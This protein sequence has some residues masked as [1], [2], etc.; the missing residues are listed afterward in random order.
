MQQPSTPA[1]RAQGGVPLRRAGSRGQ[2]APSADDLRRIGST[3][4]RGS[5]DDGVT[6]LNPQAV[7]GSSARF[8][9]QYGARAEGRA[10]YLDVRETWA[11]GALTSWTPRWLVVRYKRLEVFEF[12]DDAKLHLHSASGGVAQ[13][14]NPPLEVMELHHDRGEP[15]AIETFTAPGGRSHCVHLMVPREHG[16]PTYEAIFDCRSERDQMVWLALLRAALDRSAEDAFEAEA[17]DDAEAKSKRE[18]Q[19]QALLELLEIQK[20]E[21]RDAE[22][23]ISGY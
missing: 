5:M 16:A 10:A 21:T 4:R 3:P 19:K 9:E 6:P 14:K 12:K 15:P 17:L 8:A 11:C 7:E 13:R 2:A 1:I 18:E 22:R 23:A 20:S